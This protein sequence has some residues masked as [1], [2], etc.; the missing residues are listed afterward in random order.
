[1][2]SKR[3]QTRDKGQMKGDKAQTET[4]GKMGQ[5]WKLGWV[6]RNMTKMQ[7]CVRK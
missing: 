5:M 2:R 6:L 3:Q 7:H 1:M 4:P